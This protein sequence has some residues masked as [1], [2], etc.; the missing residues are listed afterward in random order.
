MSNVS[1]YNKYL[2]YRKNELFLEDISLAS[3]SEK[4]STPAYC[5]SIS[6]IEHNFMILKKSFHKLKPMICYAL[7]ANFNSK[8][9]KILSNLGSGIDVVSSGELEQSLSNGIDKK[10]I[11]F[12]GVGKTSKEIEIA[13]KN[14]IKQIN[15]ESEEELDEIFE[16]CKKLKKQ[17]NICLRVNPDVDA[18]THEKISTGRSEDKFGIANERIYKIFKRYHKNNFIN[19]T[20]LSI[21]IGSQIESLNPFKKAFKKI[22][23]QILNLRKEGFKVSSLDL[24]GGI[25]IKYNDKNKILDIQAYAKIIE[26]LFA[27][28]DLEIILEPGRYLVGSSGII[29][30]KVIR[31]K[32]GKEKNFLII[33]AGMNNLIR[34]ALYEAYHNIIPVRI[35]KKS[36]MKTY[37]IVG[38]ICETSDVFIKKIK[39][40]AFKK[41]DLVAICSTGAYSSCMA[42][43][44]NLK[45]LA[46]EIFIRKKNLDL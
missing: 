21:H 41:D 35:E 16:S 25:G 24:G 7:K 39:T 44:Y 43:R 9:I 23:R 13:I 45:E 28:F 29:L 33:D 34:P 40:Q 14:N 27:D 30:S 32:E 8:I 10:K 42:S 37:D 22:K 2:S 15:V 19:V 26:E 5:Y 11:V 46:D 20:G 6:Q 31:T 12:S 18:K 3:I 4:F 17:V 1:Q 36:K 38:P